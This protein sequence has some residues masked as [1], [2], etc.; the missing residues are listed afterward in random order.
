M[1]DVG[2]W[3]WSQTMFVLTFLYLCLVIHLIIYVFAF[4]RWVVNSCKTYLSHTL[5]MFLCKS[6]FECFS[7]RPWNVDLLSVKCSY[8]MA[9]C[10]FSLL[11]ALKTNASLQFIMYLWDTLTWEYHC[12][13]LVN[14]WWKRNLKGIY[15]LSSY[16]CHYGYYIRIILIIMTFLRV[17]HNIILI[18]CL[19][20]LL[21][22]GC[23]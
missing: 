10:S 17:F 11:F 14:L 18:Y 22:F 13:T 20:F 8:V 2:N 7:F 16:Y 19:K 6:M 12:Q 23:M 21:T 1:H 5:L 9:D 4:F 3:E 15:W